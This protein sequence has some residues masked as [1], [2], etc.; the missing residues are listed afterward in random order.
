MKG[1]EYG[2]RTRERE[3]VGSERKIS[4]ERR[5]AMDSY[6]KNKGDDDNCPRKMSARIL[7]DEPKM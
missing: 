7:Q 6:V 3:R 2:I 5:F 1:D 4:D